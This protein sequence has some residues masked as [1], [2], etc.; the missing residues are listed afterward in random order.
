MVQVEAEGLSADKVHFIQWALGLMEQLLNQPSCTLTMLKLGLAL[1]RLQKKVRAVGTEYCVLELTNLR[2][3][4][5]T[6][7]TPE[8]PIAVLLALQSVQSK[9]PWL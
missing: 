7:P 9:R 6:A 8:S 4:S 2:S 3:R 5:R 1:N